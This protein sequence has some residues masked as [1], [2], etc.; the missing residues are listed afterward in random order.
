MSLPSL[1]L[2][3]SPIANHNLAQRPVLIQCIAI[4]QTFQAPSAQVPDQEH[5][6]KYM[7]FDTAW[8]DTVVHHNLWYKDTKAFKHHK[9]GEKKKVIPHLHPHHPAA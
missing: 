9:H 8:L 1:D 5:P 3:E 2:A 7:N 6:E 4:N